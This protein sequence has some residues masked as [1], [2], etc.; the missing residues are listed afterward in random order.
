[1]VTR[2]AKEVTEGFSWDALW[3]LFDGDPRRL[4]IT[5]ECIDRHDPEAVAARIAFAD[6]RVDEVRF[7]HLS[8]TTSQFAHW[9]ERRGVRKGQSVGIMMEAGELHSPE[10]GGDQ[11]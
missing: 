5:N 3:A 11:Q 6:G 8:R 2:S 7:G 9:L 10:M 4:N 1:M